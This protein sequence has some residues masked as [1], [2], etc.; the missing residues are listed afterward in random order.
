MPDD[1]VAEVR[2]VESVES[3]RSEIAALLEESN[4]PLVLPER[5]CAVHAEILRLRKIIREG[6]RGHDRP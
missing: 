1:Q 4:D 5:R 6:G 2:H 3:A